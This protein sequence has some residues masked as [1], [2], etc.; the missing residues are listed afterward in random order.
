MGIA[1][2]KGGGDKLT[3]V[4]HIH[5]RACGKQIDRKDGAEKSKI[6]QQK[7]SR[8]CTLMRWH[9]FHNSTKCIMYKQNGYYGR[10]TA[11]ESSGTKK[12]GSNPFLA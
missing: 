12:D 9:L 6:Q 1:E 8:A 7:P 3:A 2:A 10:V 4:T 11:S 5:A